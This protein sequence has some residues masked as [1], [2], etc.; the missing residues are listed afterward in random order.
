MK[1]GPLLGVV[2]LVLI[3]DA[4]AMLPEGNMAVWAAQGA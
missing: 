4:A 1:V 3:K 2:A